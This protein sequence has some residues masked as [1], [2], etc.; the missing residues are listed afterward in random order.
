MLDVWSS[1]PPVGHGLHPAG[2]PAAGHPRPAA[3]SLPLPGRP[4]APHHEELRG[5]QPPRQVSTLR[6]K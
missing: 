4:G 2:A 6:Y 1:I 3:P 5:P